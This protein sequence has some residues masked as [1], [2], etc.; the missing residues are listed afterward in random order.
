MQ[1]FDTYVSEVSVRV[2]GMD[3]VP[4]KMKPLADIYLTNAALLVQGIINGQLT[5]ETLMQEQANVGKVL[6]EH[7]L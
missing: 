5:W 4:E 3:E 1:N 6:K 7:T 2:I